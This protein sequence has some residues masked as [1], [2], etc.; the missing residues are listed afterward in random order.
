M[1]KNIVVAN[2]KMNLNRVD[3]I[4]LLKDILN[5]LSLDNKTKVIFATSFIHLYKASKMCVDF[6]N[7]FIAYGLFSC[8]A[9]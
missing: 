6:N 5:R 1:R 7:I 4:A 3:G 8:A 2:W 9:T